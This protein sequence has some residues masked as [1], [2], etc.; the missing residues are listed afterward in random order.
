MNDADHPNHGGAP[1]LQGARSDDRNLSLPQAIPRRELGTEERETPPP[2]EQGPRS[3][4]RTKRTAIRIASLNI[5][6]YRASG[7]SPGDSKWYHINQLMREKRIGILLV[8][9]T[10]LTDDRKTEIESLFEKRLKLFT[11]HDPDNPSGRGGVAVVL[12]RSL[13][14]VQGV[15]STEIVP[16]RALLIQTNWH[17]EEKISILVVYAPN[18]TSTDGRENAAFWIAIGEFFTARPN[19]RVDLLAGDFNMVEDLVDRL[20]MRSDP[21]VATDALQDLTT[22]LGLVDGWR[23]T[24]PTNKTYTLLHSS[25][26][27]QSRIDRIYIS[28]QHMKTARDWRIEQTGV[29]NADHGM[30][31]VQMAHQQAP[32]VGRGRWSIPPHVIADKDL[33]RFAYESGLEA[34]AKLKKLKGRPWREDDNAQLIYNTWKKGLVNQAKERDKMI[35]PLIKA[36]IKDLEN[37]LQRANN[38]LSQNEEMRHKESRDTV[39]KLRTLERQ[40]HQNTRR[41]VAVRNRVEG[42]TICKYWTQTNKTAKPDLIYALKKDTMPEPRGGIPPSVSPRT[43]ASEPQ[44]EKDSNKMAEM[45]RSYHDTLQK[46]GQP[47]DAD[48]RQE[49]VESVLAGISATTTDA[50]KQMLNALVS[51]EEVEEALRQSKNGTAAGLDGITYEFWKTLNNRC[52]EDT[53]NEKPAFDVVELLTTVFMD[54]QKHG[55]VAS[56]KFAEGWMCPIYKKGERTEIANYRP[57]TCLNTDYKLF[58]KTLASRLAEKRQNRMA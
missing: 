3:R 17:L 22:K 21:L 40:R 58:T 51:R 33:R 37:K 45:G 10:H 27:T 38:D 35:I 48:S 19:L 6:G 4:Q 39:E 41:Q 5:R 13:T 7:S 52:V 20:P 42:E 56:T 50:Q 46:Q 31:S 29:P 25:N 9:E 44:Y 57:I 32:E 12:N 15:R 43:P 11:S 8:Q 30:V 47:L 53:K 14:N 28:P 2:P 36:K 49:K 26:G 16:G 54:I 18:V 23:E 55:M 24:F 1:Q 34:M